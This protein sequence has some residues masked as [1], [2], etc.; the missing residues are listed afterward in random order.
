MDGTFGTTNTAN[1][2]ATATVGQLPATLKVLNDCKQCHST[3]DIHKTGSLAA[4]SGGKM[5]RVHEMT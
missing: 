5:T 3:T 4:H 1:P 2:I